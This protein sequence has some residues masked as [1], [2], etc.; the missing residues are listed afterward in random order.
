MFRTGSKQVRNSFTP[1]FAPR[2]PWSPLCS[3]RL[4]LSLLRPRLFLLLRL[5]L[6]RLHVFLAA[7][8]HARNPS[9]PGIRQ[10]DFHFSVA[11]EHGDV[12]GFRSESR[13][14]ILSPFG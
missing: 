14:R 9:R 3:L 8:G 7:E 1:G 12:A 4:R 11:F 13:E 10:N 5:L 2:K 6:Q